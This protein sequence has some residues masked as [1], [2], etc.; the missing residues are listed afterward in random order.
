MLRIAFASFLCVAGLGMLV[1]VGVEW[2]AS[3]SSCHEPPL[4]AWL[5]T[6]GVVQV[7]AVVVSFLA[8]HFLYQSRPERTCPSITLA[9]VSRLLNLFL[10]SWFIV[11][12]VWL[13]ASF[14][15]TLSCRSELPLSWHVMLVFLIS[16]IFALLT[17]TAFLIFSC[18]TVLTRMMMIHAGGG[19]GDGHSMR[20]GASSE[21]ITENSELR[22]F[23]AALFPDVED[24][25]CVV[26]LGDYAEGD[27]LRYLRCNHHFHVE[28]IDEWLKRQGSCPLCVRQLDH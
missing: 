17:A 18:I 27:Q 21:E 12:L 15:T 23:D 19:G 9:L 24:A 3:A 8:R 26:C 28:C 2:K 7:V 10:F 1:V 14:N 11:G 20:R 13:V 25:K 4:R 5:M 6:Q 16:E 22:P